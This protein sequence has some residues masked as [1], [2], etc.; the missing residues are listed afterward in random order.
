MRRIAMLIACPLVLLAFA[1]PAFAESPD[2]TANGILERTHVDTANGPRPIDVLSTTTGPRVV[3]FPAGHPVP[4]DGAE[5]RLSGHMAGNTLETTAATVTGPSLAIP[6]SDTSSSSAPLADAGDA[7]LASGVARTVAIVVI[8]FS[9]G[10]A[11]SY[12]D[13]QLRG[14]LTQNADSVSNY[15]AEQSYGQVSFQGITNPAG[16][17]YRVPIASNGSGCSSNWSTWGSQAYAAAGGNAVLGAYNH[18]IYVFNS[19]NTC[20][21]AGLGYMPGSS[22][23]I[24]NYFQL[25]VV[26]HELGHNLGVHHASSLRCIVNG[27][28][29]AFANANGACS[30]SEYGD[31]YDIMGS[32]NTNQQNAFHKFQSGWLGSVS[33]PRVQ[34]ITQSGD[35]TVNPLE[36]SSGVAL[37]LIPGVTSGSDTNNSPTTNLGQDFALDLRQPFGTQFD[38]FPSDSPAVGGINI[39]LVQTPGTGSPVQTQL[40]D[41][42]PQTSSFLDAALT[43]GNTFTD[44]ADGITI[45]NEGITPLV[46]AT[47]HVTLGATASSPDTTPPSAVGDLTATVAAGPVVTVSFAA[48]TDNAGVS[49]YRIARDGAQIASLPATTTSY[50]DWTA[51]PGVHVYTVTAIDLSGNVGATTSTTATVIAPTTTTTPTPIT[52]TPTTPTTPTG[53]TTKLPKTKVKNAPHVKAK[54]ISVKGKTRRVLVTW[55]RVAGSRSYVVLRNGRRLASTTAHTLVDPSAPRG[56]LRYVVRA[57]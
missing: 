40:I 22:V 20:G 4:P 52:P 57:S 36:L 37:L 17:I 21:W 28:A 45:T 48:A 7:P 8:T 1:V 53:P 19:Q 35:Y 2:V 44:Y 15:F 32:S 34:T 27:Q 49:S 55:Q 18:V 29:V 41:T 30:S 25:S 14:V 26:A 16:D 43:Q 31:P 42:T 3:T 54:V 9:T 23:Y 11:P 56:A 24:D 13:A 33:G 51:G 50:A 38:A 5:V 46:G 12:T 39:H 6:T 47:V 10:V